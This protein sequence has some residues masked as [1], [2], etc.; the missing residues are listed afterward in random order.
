[1]VRADV[2][3]R[4]F[5]SFYRCGSAPFPDSCPPKF[6][7]RKFRWVNGGISS[8]SSFRK[9]GWAKWVRTNSRILHQ[10]I[11]SRFLGEVEIEDGKRAKFMADASEQVFGVYFFADGNSCEVPRGAEKSVCKVG[12]LSCCIFLSVGAGSLSCEKFNRPLARSLLDRLAKGNRVKRI[13]NCALLGR[14][15]RETAVV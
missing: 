12:Q 6:S 7:E 9:K 10:M 4:F 1:M 2:F 13:G 11:L 3:N 8:P 15:E 14:K 5:G